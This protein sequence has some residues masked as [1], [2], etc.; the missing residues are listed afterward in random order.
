MA[1]NP[2]S[3]TARVERWRA[4]L[5]RALRAGDADA[6][7][8]A[9][10]RITSIDPNDA[11]AHYLAG[12]CLFQQGRLAA[13]VDPLRRATELAPARPDYQNAL[14]H[15]LANKGRHS[16]AA[17]HFEAA[18]GLA[19]ENLEVQSDFAQ[20]LIY[21]GEL[22]RARS[23]AEQVVGINPDHW[24]AHLLLASLLDGPAPEERAEQLEAALARGAGAAVVPSGLWAV[25]RPDLL[26][27]GV[28]AELPADPADAAAHGDGEAVGTGAN[29]VGGEQPASVDAPVNSGT[30]TLSDLQAPVG[31]GHGFGSQTSDSIQLSPPA[32]PQASSVKT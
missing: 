29:K 23:V 10:G 21:L 13:A 12:L 27:R 1:T 28:G 25:L 3:D 32:S 19:P 30:D 26:A 31:C 14:G 7:M 17:Q 15:A 11:D 8:R 4:K 2:E 20:A 24:R 5:I 18:A 16:V 22:D 9:A 6:A